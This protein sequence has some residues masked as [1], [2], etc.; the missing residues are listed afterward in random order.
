MFTKLVSIILSFVMAFTSF[1]STAFSD[2]IDSVSEMLFG[3]PYTVEAIKYDFFSELDDGD[4]VELEDDSGFIND[5]IAVFVDP[6]MTFS[7]KLDFFTNCGGVLAGWCTPADLYVIS[8]PAMTYEQ[9]MSKCEEFGKKEGIELSVPVMAY[10]TETNLTP[11]DPFGST[12]D[13]PLVW[14]EVVPAGDNWWL[15]AIDARQAWDYYDNFS[16]I[17]IGVIDA[18]YETEHPELAGKI[19]FPDEK[20]ARRNIP[21][22]HGTHVAGIIAANHNEVGIAGVCDNSNLICIDWLP[23]MLQFWSTDISI[24]FGF[25]TLVKEGAKVVNLSLG[26]SGS[27]ADNSSGFVERVIGTAATSYMMASLLSKGYDFV[28]VQSAGNGDIFGDPVDAV[29]NGHFSALTEDNIFVG[30]KNVSAQDILNRI[31]IV[32]SAS[33]NGDGTYTQSDFTNVGSN[34]SIAAPGEDIY[35]CSLNGGYEVFSGTSMS[36]PIVTGV[37][38]LVWSVNPSFTGAQVKEIICTATDSVADIY[39]ESEYYY[40]VELMEYPMVNAKLAVEEA[41]RRT[42]LS[43]GTVS[44]KIVGSAET[45]V[46]SGVAHTVYS[47]GTYSF[48]APESSGTAEIF[49]RYGN[50]IGSFELTVIAAQTTVAEDYNVENY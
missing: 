10:K 2:I 3:I 24:F 40:E 30:S 44:G 35:S 31:I 5:K 42:D 23:D 9:I 45:I 34:V 25:S 39:T 12:E 29:N 13:E 32:A 20:Q 22:S 7:Q 36:A 16:K 28:V 43:V 46:Y 26:T 33:N 50:S 17:N 15:E 11:S 19:S 48:V 41:I 8:Y 4:V 47:D 18:G 49:D 6:D 27:K 14:D 1:I 38:S 21:D 37:A